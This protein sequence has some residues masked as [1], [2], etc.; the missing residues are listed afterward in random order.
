MTPGFLIAAIIGGVMLLIFAKHKHTASNIK[1]ML[2]PL[3]ARKG[4]SVSERSFLRF[5]I[6]R[7]MHEGLELQLLSTPAAKNTP[8]YT[9]IRFERSTPL[10]FE[11]Y[12]ES[13]TSSLGKMLGFSEIE[14]GSADFDEAFVLKS[15]SEMIFRQMLSANLQHKLLQIKQ[16]HP[17]IKLKNGRFEL[18]VPRIPAS[19][20]EY[21]ILLQTAESF[22]GEL[23]RL[24]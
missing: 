11:I 8:P 4:G 13:F 23:K 14:I 19:D 21:E 2:E 9:F 22:V 3:A 20:A 15:D 17:R 7:Y 18:R 1:K 16:F 6:L 5:P 12:N 10:Q 24:M